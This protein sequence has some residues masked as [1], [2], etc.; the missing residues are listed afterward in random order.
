MTDD[1]RR[2]VRRDS[3]AALRMTK[4]TN[5]E[6]V[7]DSTLAMRWVVVK[8]IAATTEPAW[9]TECRGHPCGVE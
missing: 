1:G 8:S 3:F 9:T 4:K 6:L 7:A 5:A 2:S